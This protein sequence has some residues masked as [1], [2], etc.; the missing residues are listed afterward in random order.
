MGQVGAGKSSL[1]QALLGEMEKHGGNVS[2]KVTP[3]SELLKIGSTLT[4]GQ[5]G[6]C[7]P[8]GLD[9]ECHSERQR[10]LW[11]ELGQCQVSE[12]Y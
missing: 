1:I 6:I 9:P 7:P 2:L 11:K 10:P 3:N 4:P 8:A 5:C 12:N